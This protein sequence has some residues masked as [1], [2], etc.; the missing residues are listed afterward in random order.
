MA[1]D[2]DGRRPDAWAASRWLPVYPVGVPCVLS[3]AASPRPRL[4]ERTQVWSGRCL[5]A[6]AAT[7]LW[8]AARRG[9]GAPGHLLR[10]YVFNVGGDT[11]PAPER[12]L[13][14]SATVAVK[15]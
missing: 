1:H 4:C 10:G 13:E 3:I 15:L 6:V 14:L 7:G 11:P 2:A 8:S 9:G 12:V 5:H